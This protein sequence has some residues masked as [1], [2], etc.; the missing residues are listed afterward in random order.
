MHSFRP[1][2]L[3]TILI[4]S[5]VIVGFWPSYYGLMFSGNLD[6]WLCVFGC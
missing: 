5:I 4:A 3:A 6:V 1:Y 2:Q